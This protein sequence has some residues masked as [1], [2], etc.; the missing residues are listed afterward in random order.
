[1]LKREYMTPWE[2][3][4]PTNSCIIDVFIKLKK[5]A[6]GW[7]FQYNASEWDSGC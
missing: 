7:T 1:V 6:L 4:R 3:R 2:I 5:H